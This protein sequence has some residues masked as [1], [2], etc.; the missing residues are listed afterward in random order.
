MAGEMAQWLGALVLAEDLGLVPSTHTRLHD[1]LEVLE[2][3]LQEIVS[4]LTSVGTRYAHTHAHAHTHTHTHTH[5]Y[6]HTTF[7]HIKHILYCPWI[8]IA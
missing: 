1:H 6:T 5:T 3:Q 4:L 7:R 8:P 2:V